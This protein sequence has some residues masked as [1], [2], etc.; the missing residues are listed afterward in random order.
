[1]PGHFLG[2]KML[3]L[4]HASYVEIKEPDIHYGRKNADFGQGFYTSQDYSFVTKW[5]IPKKDASIY[6]NHYVLDDSGLKIKRFT[7]DEEWFDYIYNNRRVKDI[8]LDFDV[9]IGP[10]ANDTIYDT[11]GMTTSGFLS[12]EEAMK[13]LMVG[14]CY[15]QTVIKSSAA[16]KALKWIKTD[17]LPDSEASKN[18][19]FVKKEEQSYQEELARIMSEFDT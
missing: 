12:K 10:I 2:E 9:I 7:R 18:I 1:M 11:L 8:L 17:I 5:V 3:N 14:P 13:L 19:D 16:S 15:D 4:Y 6:I